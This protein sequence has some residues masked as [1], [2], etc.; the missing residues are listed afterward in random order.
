MEGWWFAQCSAAPAASAKVRC[1]AV[2]QAGP[3]VS[4]SPYMF[5]AMPNAMIQ[6]RSYI[7]LWGDCGLRSAPPL[8][9]PSQLAG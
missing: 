9:L 7:F 3:L 2:A 8:P 1:F 6:K 5:D 4:K